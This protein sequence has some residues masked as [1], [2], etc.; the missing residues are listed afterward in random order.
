M[1]SKR[2]NPVRD[3]ENNESAFRPTIITGKALE[4]HFELQNALLEFSKLFAY[5][6]ENDRSIAIV[7][8]TFVDM[9]LEQI[10]V[11]YLIDDEKELKRLLGCDQPL[12]TYSGRVTMTYCLGLINNV[13]RD[14]LRLVGRI[15]NRFA[16]D[17]YAS[18]DDDSIKA[19][20]THLQWHKVAFVANPPSDATARDLYQVGVHQ[21]VCYLNGI[22][23]I[24]RMQKCTRDLYS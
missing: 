11:A 14:D 6:E 15:R 16:H 4:R 9:L 1:L 18:F 23:V 3:N 8:A 10:L 13:V 19:C 12:G 5:D 24:A 7:G 17:L 20:C 22:V 21:L 2:G